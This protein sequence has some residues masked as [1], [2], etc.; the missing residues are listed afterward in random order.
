MAGT[1]TLRTDKLGCEHP[2]IRAR[3]SGFR[4]CLLVPLRYTLTSGGS[5]ANGLEGHRLCGLPCHQAQMHPA[6]LSGSSAKRR[7]T[8]LLRT[9]RFVVPPRAPMLHTKVASRSSSFV[10]P[11]LPGAGARPTHA[12]QV[13]AAKASERWREVCS[14][15]RRQPALSP[16]SEPAAARLSDDEQQPRARRI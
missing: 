5:F 16:P 4:L 2:G 7:G 6:T 11:Y 15:T 8:V 10:T 13:R 14:A 12:N 3:R 9:R 1:R